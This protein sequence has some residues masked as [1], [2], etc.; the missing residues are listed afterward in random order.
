MYNMIEDTNDANNNLNNA[1]DRPKSP[2]RAKEEEG[3]K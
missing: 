1:S 2:G 3:K